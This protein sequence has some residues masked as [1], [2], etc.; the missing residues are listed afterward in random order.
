MAKE[1]LLQT[2]VSVENV[3]HTKETDIWAFGMVIYVRFAPRLSKSNASIADS[4]SRKYYQ[5]RNLTHL[6]LTVKSQ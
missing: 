6:L 5:E 3:K 2:S 1:L 4:I